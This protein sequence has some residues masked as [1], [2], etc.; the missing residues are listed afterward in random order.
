MATYTK[1]QIYQFKKTEHF[2]IQ[3]FKRGIDDSILEIVLKYYQDYDKEKVLALFT[4]SFLESKNI[5]SPNQSHL[6]IIIKFNNLLITTFWC[7]SIVEYYK[8]LKIKKG[9]IVKFPENVII[10]EFNIQNI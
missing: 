4:Y 7:N 8:K 6:I 10:N 3:A 1:K 5:K 9:I 2:I